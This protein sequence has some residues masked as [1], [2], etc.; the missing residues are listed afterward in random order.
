MGFAVDGETLVVREF[1][2][3]GFTAEPINGPVIP[4]E[5]TPQYSASVPIHILFGS[6]SIIVAL[7]IHNAD[8]IVRLTAN[9]HTVASYHI[10]HFF[11]DGSGNAATFSMQQTL[12]MQIHL[13]TTIILAKSLVVEV[14]F[15][16]QELPTGMN[17]RRLFIRNQDIHHNLR[18]GHTEF[19]TI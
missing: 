7:D 16:I 8:G 6:N 19:G 18:Y 12:G 4:V 14:R 11:R 15:T 9:G 13:V 2:T 17:C 5:P 1:L 10:H 3:P